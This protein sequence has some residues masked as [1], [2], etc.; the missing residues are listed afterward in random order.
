M[1]MASGYINVACSPTR[2][3][4]QTFSYITLTRSPSSACKS[5]STYQAKL[6]NY[7]MKTIKLVAPLLTLVAGF[8]LALAQDVTDCTDIS[9]DLG[10]TP[11][12]PVTGIMVFIIITSQQACMHTAVKMYQL[13]PF[14]VHVQYNLCMHGLCIQHLP[15]MYGT[16][17]RPSMPAPYNVD[18][19]TPCMCENN[20]LYD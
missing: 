19:I 7:R 10:T 2:L 14:I 6:Y 20:G 3:R 13:Q 16:I 15:C 18:N 8:Q 9:V 1:R 17:M 11:I 4:K 12:T 5:A